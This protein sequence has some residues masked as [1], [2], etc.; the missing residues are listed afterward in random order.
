MKSKDISNRLIKASI[1]SFNINKLYKRLSFKVK[2]LNNI[3]NIR[4]INKYK[5]IYF[6][7]N[8]SSKK[9]IKSIL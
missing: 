6:K 8:E 1:K 3:N 4:S 7:V 2:E 5:A 9:Y